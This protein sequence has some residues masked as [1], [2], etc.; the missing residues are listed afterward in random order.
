[1]QNSHACALRAI[2]ISAL[3]HAVRGERRIESCVRETPLF[4]S[5]GLWDRFHGARL[6]GS[7]A[8]AAFFLA[9]T[10]GLS[11]PRVALCDSFCSDCR[12]DPRHLLSTMHPSAARPMHCTVCRCLLRPR[13]CQIASGR[14]LAPPPC[15]TAPAFTPHA[16][17]LS[18]STRTPSAAPPRCAAPTPSTRSS[19][20][21]PTSS[22][23]AALCAPA[24]SPPPGP[25]TAPR[26]RTETPLPRPAAAERELRAPHR[27]HPRPPGVRGR[28]PRPRR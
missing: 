20:P 11:T 1:M 9:S 28:S 18:L 5:S 14:V 16:R 22:T 8:C 7:V 3:P 23:P 2:T 27:V 6:C 24:S 12:G 26:T 15:A 21:R 4:C 17:R 10:R 19:S 13:R 25:H